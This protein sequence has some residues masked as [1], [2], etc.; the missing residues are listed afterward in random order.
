MRNGLSN[1][2]RALSPKS[3]SQPNRG[4]HIGDGDDCNDWEKW[5]ND[6]GDYVEDVDNLIHGWLDWSSRG[7]EC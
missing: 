6:Y 2:L 3:C 5:C 1:D 7:R 4:N